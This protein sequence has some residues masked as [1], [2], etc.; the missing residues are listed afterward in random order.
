VVEDQ[1]SVE[2]VLSRVAEKIRLGRS[3]RR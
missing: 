2:V 3:F 1:S